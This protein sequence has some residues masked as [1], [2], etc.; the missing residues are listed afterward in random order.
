MAQPNFP[1]NNYLLLKGVMAHGVRVPLTALLVICAMFACTT[2]D[3][4]DDDG[5]SIDE[6]AERVCWREANA[7]ARCVTG[8]RK[9]ESDKKRESGCAA[10]RAS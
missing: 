1:A 7:F 2:Q 9:K 4:E 5:V 6:A 10:S 3:A 8:Q